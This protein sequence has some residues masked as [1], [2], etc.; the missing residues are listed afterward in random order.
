[1]VGVANLLCLYLFFTKP[2]PHPQTNQNKQ[3]K[4]KVIGSPG[5]ESNPRT[6][7]AAV[8][9]VHGEALSFVHVG[10]SFVHS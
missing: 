3:N 4:K 1:M 8:G 5:W 7:E 2:P 9:F 6:D 10:T